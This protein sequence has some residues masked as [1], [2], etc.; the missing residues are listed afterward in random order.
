MKKQIKRFAPLCVILGFASWCC[1]Q[2]LEKQES[3]NVF[4]QNIAPPSIKRADLEPAVRGHSPRDPFA[5]VQRR[6]PPQPTKEDPTI[7]TS[8]NVNSGVD[9]TDMLST[10]KLNAT[11]VRG[12][13]RVAMINSQA[14]QEGESFDSPALVDEPATLTRVLHDAVLL[15][16]QGQQYRLSYNGLALVSAPRD[17]GQPAAAAG[18]TL[19]RSLLRMLPRKS[20]NHTA[21]Q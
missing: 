9:L 7:L 20:P 15:D 19:F 1:W 12:D 11:Y 17:D 5:I 10:L 4:D 14:F 6:E 3:F 18:H 2:S 16:V 8:V 13:R 21:P